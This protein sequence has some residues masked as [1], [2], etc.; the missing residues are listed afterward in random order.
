MA[1]RKVVALLLEH[2]FVGLVT[3]GTQVRLHELRFSDL[4]RIYFLLGDQG[5]L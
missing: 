2:A 5:D 1:T 4:S 3:F